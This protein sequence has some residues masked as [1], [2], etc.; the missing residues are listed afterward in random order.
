MIFKLSP[1]IPDIMKMLPLLLLQAICLLFLFGCISL[2]QS[3][4]PASLAPKTRQ[5]TF[6]GRKMRV[7]PQQ[8]GTKSDPALTVEEPVAEPETVID[9]APQNVEV[10]T[11]P[12]TEPVQAVPETTTPDTPQVQ[13]AP[14]SASS[15]EQIF[16]YKQSLAEEKQK[17]SALQ[18]LVEAQTA[19]ATEL[20]KMVKDQTAVMALL[21]NEISTLKASSQTSKPTPAHGDTIAKL[22]AQVAEQA[23]GKKALEAEIKETKALLS[24]EIEKTADRDKKLADKTAELEALSKKQEDLE[25]SYE[26]NLVKHQDKDEEIKTEIRKEKEAV[27]LINQRQEK[28]ID[29]LNAE[30]KKLQIENQRLARMQP[31]K[32]KEPESPPSTSTPVIPE[33]TVP[34]LPPVVTPPPAPEPAPV[35]A[36]DPS[37]NGP[38]TPSAPPSP[39]PTPPPPAAHPFAPA[40]Q[41]QTTPPPAIPVGALPPPPSAPH[42]F[43]PAT[44]SP[45]DT[46]PP[47]P[48]QSSP[49]APTGTSKSPPAPR[50]V[51]PTGGTLPT[52]PPP[53]PPGTNPFL[54]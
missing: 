51:S 20:E 19:K 32:T 22:E 30:I 39:V 17:S 8:V 25:K 11:A 27:V 3:T 1:N 7:E 48:P 15:N 35:P 31:L 12:L 44:P 9:S 38:A 41:N 53:P 33:P 45:F 21:N 49:F 36:P 52:P 37:K 14:D 28:E 26:E 29:E 47:P 2:P 18:A 40:P 5:E 10:E 43:A 42:P 46:T 16:Q 34:A 4:E 13:P 54:Q 6:Q 24:Q 23:S 50:V